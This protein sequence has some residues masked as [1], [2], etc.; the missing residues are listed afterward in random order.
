MASTARRKLRHNGDTLFLLTGELGIHL[1]GTDTV[2][3][4]SEEVNTIRIFG[5]IGKHI[6]NASSQGKLTRLIHIVL[7]HK[8]QFRKLVHNGLH[9]DVL[10]HFELEGMGGEF[11]AR[12]HLLG[13]RIGI[14]HHTQGVALLQSAQHLRT[15]DFIPCILL[16]V[17]DG[18]TVR[19]GKEQYIRIAIDL[20]QIVVE[21]ARLFGITQ[22]KNHGTGKVV[23]KGRKEQRGSGGMQ[24]SQ[25]NSPH[26][27]I[28]Q[29][30]GQ[31]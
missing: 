6:D 29:L 19:R 30:L 27:G 22:D 23:Q 5:R 12:H 11:L 1:K 4:I 31:P 24:S 10:T 13:Q 28:L 3:L 16:P 20:H 8:P 18:T 26:R 2:Y 15:E 21:I 7:T 14:G 9:R 25:E 17:L